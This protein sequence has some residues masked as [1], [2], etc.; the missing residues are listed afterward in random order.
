MS[1]H[2]H[3]PALDSA[4]RRRLGRRAQLLAGA[5][6]AYNAIEAVVAIT[7]G[8]VAGSVALVGFGLDSIVEVSSG[9]I[10][11]WQFRHPIPESRERSALRLMAL[12]FFGL[13]AYVTFESVRTLASGHD[14]DSSPVG[15]ALAVASLIIMPFLSWAQ[16]R[17][18]KSLGSNAVVAD[19]TQTLLCTY[20]SAVL[21]VGLVLNATLGWSWAD[22]V[23][24]LVIAVVAVREGVEAWR[25]EG[26]ACGPV[27]CLPDATTATGASQ[28]DSACGCNDDAGGCTDGC[29][30]PT[31]VVPHNVT[32]GRREGIEQ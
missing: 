16:R 14:P 20:L 15:I 3:A 32:I 24:G 23:A 8:I 28:S 31:D 19:S 26:C 10:I 29:C 11:L 25:G 18:G 21:L 17:T 6:V 5:S 27:A 2:A 12:S 4:E 22:P 30:P 13:A 1:A 7:A 9:L